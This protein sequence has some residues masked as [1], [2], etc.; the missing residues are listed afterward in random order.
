MNL[1]RWQS[2][3]QPPS[4]APKTVNPGKI[5]V[6]ASPEATTAPRCKPIAH[7]IPRIC[8]D[9]GD[10]L[11]PPGASDWKAEFMSRLAGKEHVDGWQD[12]YAKYLSWD[13]HTPID[14]PL[15]PLAD[16]GANVA[17][18]LHDDALSG[19]SVSIYDAYLLRADVAKNENEF[20]RYQIV[21]SPFSEQYTLISRGGRVGLSGDGRIVTYSGDLNVPVRKFE[22]LFLH[23]TGYTWQGRYTPP[24]F[25]PP[26]SCPGLIHVDLDYSFPTNNDLQFLKSPKE[27]PSGQSTG[28]KMDEPCRRLLEDVLFGVPTRTSASVSS[29]HQP[30]QPGIAASPFTAPR[31][32][33]SLWTVMTAFNILRA[34]TFQL[35]PKINKPHTVRW[36]AIVQASTMYRSAIPY[37]GGGFNRER[38]P[39]ISNYHAVLIELEYLHSLTRR[40]EIAAMMNDMKSRV[41]AQLSAHG[42]MLSTQPLYQAYSS[43]RHA[44]RPLEDPF[45][46]EFQQLKSYLEESCQSQTHHM[47]FQLQGIYRV[48]TKPRLQNPYHDWIQSSTTA[49]SSQPSRLLLWHGTPLSSLLGILEHGLQIRKQYEPPPP[50]YRKAKNPPP[51]APPPYLGLVPGK[52]NT[53]RI[54]KINAAAARQ[55]RVLAQRRWSRGGMFGDGIYLADASSKSAGYCQ[56]MATSNGEAV[57]LLCEADVGEEGKRLR[58]YYSLQDGHDIMGEFGGKDPEVRCIEGVGRTGP[59]SVES[60]GWRRV[61]WDLDGGGPPRGDGLDV[62]MVSCLF[63]F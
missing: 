32:H 21:Y 30:D 23:S 51:P 60:G 31:Q 41:T 20:M 48:Y 14:V 36:K 9:W 53:S 11:L 8:S 45:S 4:N 39:V 29:P 40:G 47:S 57:L 13:Y 10:D 37:Y 19:L 6:G 5:H 34:I 24:K 33:L 58:S 35:A 12:L 1:Y 22:E 28:F 17:I 55:R 63:F 49:P 2:Q 52:I 61:G 44:F 25:Q 16:I 42:H 7:P 18:R 62:W 50:R 43:L 54:L 3:S 56:A 15:D 59:R 46:Y 26:Q 27:A 38:P